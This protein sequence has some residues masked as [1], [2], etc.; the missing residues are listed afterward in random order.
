MATYG[1]FDVY[2]DETIK[3]SPDNATAG[4]DFTV[5]NLSNGYVYIGS[6]SNVN[7]NSFGYRLSPGAA[8]SVELNGKD[9]IWAVA[10]YNNSQVATFA[11]GLEP[12]G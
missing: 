6:D 10:Q 12:M 8:W 4:R 3:V 5:Q 9:E 11:L 2:T 7:Q 1:L